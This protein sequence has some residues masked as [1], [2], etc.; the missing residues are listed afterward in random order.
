MADEDPFPVERVRCNGTYDELR[1]V[2]Q[3]HQVITVQV[4]HIPRNLNWAR[5]N[6]QTEGLV[7]IHRWYSVAW[8]QF[9]TP[10]QAC[11]FM[12]NTHGSTFEGGK[13]RAQGLYLPNT[14]FEEL[15]AKICAHLEQY[16]LHFEEHSEV[17][18]V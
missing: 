13:L 14:G 12:V 8:H 5:T 17:F 4:T 11:K 3:R 10:D 6:T 16:D 18:H 15:L 2:F 1:P 7:K 9:Q